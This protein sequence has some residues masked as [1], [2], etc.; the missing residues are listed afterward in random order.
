MKFKIVVN[1]SHRLLICFPQ[2]SHLFWGFWALIQSANS[3]ID[4]DF[5]EYATARLRQYDATKDEFLALHLEHN[6]K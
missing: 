1:K 3:D 4:F 2:A 6:G 5:L